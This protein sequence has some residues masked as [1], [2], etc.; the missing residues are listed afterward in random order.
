MLIELLSGT[1]LSKTITATIEDDTIIP[2]TSRIALTEAE[3]ILCRKQGLDKAR[4]RLE[5]LIQSRVIEIVED[6]QLFLEAAKTKCARSI[7]L[8][9]CFTLALAEKIR[10]TALFT[11]QEDD[12]EV[13]MLRKPFSQK[14]HFL[15]PRPEINPTIQSSRTLREPQSQARRQSSQSTTTKAL[16]RKP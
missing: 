8:G 3:Y 5:K 15:E 14:I 16:Y 7:A 4:D 10:G 11:R 12:L 13:E 9:D 1:P 6:D 2:Y